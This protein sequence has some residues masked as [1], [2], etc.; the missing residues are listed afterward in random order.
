MALAVA[1]TSAG[2]CTEL[3]PALAAGYHD[4]IATSPDATARPDLIFPATP[5]SSTLFTA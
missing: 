4:M 3:T 5:A 1:L 2:I